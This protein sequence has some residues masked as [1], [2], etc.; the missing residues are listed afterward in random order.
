[1]TVPPSN[2]QSKDC[3][4][5]CFCLFLRS[6]LPLFVLRSPPV[7]LSSWAKVF[8]ASPWT[9]QS[10]DPETTYP[11]NISR[12]SP[13][14]FSSTHLQKFHV[15]HPPSFFPYPSLSVPVRAIRVIPLPFSALCIRIPPI[16]K[17]L[18]TPKT[19][20][21]PATRSFQAKYKFPKPGLLVMVNSL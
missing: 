5:T 10:R 3:G 15:E 7:K 18:S 6:C 8:T 12:L 9:P 16:P 11:P 1:M 2:T 4:S 13:H 14:A 19:V 17:I 20:E 21:I